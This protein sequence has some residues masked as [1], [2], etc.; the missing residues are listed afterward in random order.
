MIQNQFPVRRVP[1]SAVSVL[2]LP[3]E[4]WVPPQ[5]RPQVPE[6]GPHSLFLQEGHLQA[7]QV[8]E[9]AQ[10]QGPPVAAEAVG[11]QLEERQGPR[12]KASVE[13][14]PLVQWEVYFKI[15]EEMPH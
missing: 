14:H 15:F 3:A 13:A 10:L 6:E 4:L 5:P 9:P 11:V 7:L 2:L 1:G 8:Q 12:S